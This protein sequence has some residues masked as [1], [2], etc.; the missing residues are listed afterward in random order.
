MTN[1]IYEILLFILAILPSALIHEVA[2]GYV[3]FR[4]GD[5][6][7][8][9]AGRLTLNPAKHIDLFT[10]VI[11]PIGMALV[12]LPPLILF[13][14]VPVIMQ[15]L[16]NPRR[17]S[18]LVALA[19]P[20]SNILL[21]GTVILLYRGLLI[22]F[23]PVWLYQYLAFFV[24]INLV[25]AAFNLI[26]IP[27]LDGSWILTSYLYGKVL[28]MFVRIRM[29]LVIAFLF[30]LLSGFFSRFFGPVWDFIFLLANRLLPPP[31]S[32]FPIF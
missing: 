8:K 12:N 16:N 4:L 32:F 31:L 1:Q 22:H 18:R 17:D 13:K 11:L 3:A 14:P 23:C 21:A 30:L 2:H 24:I 26:P 25:L 7:A 19:G 5:P 29:Y 27:P 20:L 15:N 9:L 10:T 6:T 28:E